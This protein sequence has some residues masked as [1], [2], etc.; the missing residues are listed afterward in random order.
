M[1]NVVITRIVRIGTSQG[2]HLPKVWV[3]QLHLGPEVEMTVQADG[4]II[5]PAV[6][7]GQAWDEQFAAMAD[8]GDDRLIDEPVVNSFD[9]DQWEW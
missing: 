3:D 5:R 2:V 4:I 9:K 1:N 8:A 7:A 6:R